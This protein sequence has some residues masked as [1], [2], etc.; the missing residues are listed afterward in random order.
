[1]NEP[2]FKPRSL[3]PEATWTTVWIGVGSG[4][5]RG[6][7]TIVGTGD[8]SVEEQSATYRLKGSIAGLQVVDHSGDGC[9]PESFTL[10]LGVGTIYWAGIN[11]PIPVGSTDV[12][13]TADIILPGSYGVELTAEDQDGEQLFCV[14]IDFRV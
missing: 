6:D 7:G 11:C 8:L 3:T 10:P 13:V 5:G 9:S 14:K 12:A 1:M 2:A 4:D